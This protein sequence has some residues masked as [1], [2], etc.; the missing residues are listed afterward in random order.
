MNI[1]VINTAAE[2]AGSLSI[3][4]EFY[5]EVKQLNDQNTWIFCVSKLVYLKSND[6][7]VF[8]YSWT[9]KSWIHR[10]YFDYFV[11]RKLVKK[12]NIDLVFS[13]Q[14][15][16]FPGVKIKQIVYFHQSIQFSPYKY[17]FLKPKEL[18]FW[19]RQNVISFYM[20]KSLRKANSIIV[21][22]D[23]FQAR[24]ND[25]LSPIKIPIHIV[26]PIINDFIKFD[27]DLESA[28][29]TFFYPAGGGHH[30]NHDI[31]I[32]A[33]L[34]LKSYNIND[35]KVIFTLDGSEN[36]YVKKIYKRVSEHGLPIVFIGNIS[37]ENVFRYYSMSTVLFPSVIETFGLPLLEAKLAKSIVFASNLPFSHEILDGYENSRFFNMS[38]HD[39]LFELMRDSIYGN[40]SYRTDKQEDIEVKTF[41][42][43]TILE[44]T[45]SNQYE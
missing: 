26:K 41:L 20:R 40:I 22:S 3:L 31:I 5:K 39:S 24:V 36:Q 23:W 13:M 2:Y 12:L 34:K 42:H 6:G 7:D 16:T 29:N 4:Q 15:V 30:K 8:E 9:K 43:K 17:S 38:S 18:N 37:K 35:Y 11:V 33:C 45:S 32:D 19:V 1:L 10:L 14:N 21:Q 44:L 28:K 25:W 27:Y